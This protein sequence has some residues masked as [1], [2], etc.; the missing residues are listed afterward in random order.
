MPE[1]KDESAE[2][3]ALEDDDAVAASSVVDGEDE[4]SVVVVNDEGVWLTALEL[5]EEAKVIKDGEDREG[6]WTGVCDSGSERG[7]GGKERG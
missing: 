5:D 2:L 3:A 6:A 4:E 1:D 7:R